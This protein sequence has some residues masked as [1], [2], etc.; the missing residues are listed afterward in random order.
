MPRFPTRPNHAT[1]VA[2][3]ALSVALGGGAYAAAALP[4]GSVGTKQ[5][6]NGAVTTP[7]LATSAVTARDV[8]SH[9]LT[10]AQI[11]LT[12]LGTVPKASLA[13]NASHAAQADNATAAAVSRYQV[14]S[15]VSQGGTFT[16]SV[17]PNDS[18]SGSQSCPQGTKAF[19]GGLTNYP[20]DI[21]VTSSQPAADGSAWDVTASNS[22]STTTH[23]LD[24]WVVCAS[25][26]S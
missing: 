20:S 25:A 22:S 21:T 5:L 19:S 13:T 7:K 16:F 14:R 1:V 2:Y 26:T 23:L 12:K 10:G 9:S 17:A 11:N 3:L 15:A 24:V 4:N 18:N 6:K 8:A